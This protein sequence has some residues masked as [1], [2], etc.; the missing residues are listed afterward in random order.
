[1]PGGR[2]QAVVLQRGAEFRGGGHEVIWFHLGEADLG[3]LL[4]GAVQVFLQGL[5]EGVQLD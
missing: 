4:D 2:G 3:H 5:A 1:M